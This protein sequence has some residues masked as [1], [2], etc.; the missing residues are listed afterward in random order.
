MIPEQ[1]QPKRRAAR[2]A[3]R[4]ALYPALMVALVVALFFNPRARAEYYYVRWIH[5]TQE[6]KQIKYFEALLAT[7][8][9]QPHAAALAPE[10]IAFYRWKEIDQLLERGDGEVLVPALL[11]ELDTGGTLENLVY[12]AKT[13]YRIDPTSKEIIPIIIG[14]LNSKDAAILLGDIIV[15][16]KTVPP[17]LI[18][19][20]DSGGDRVAL[21]L[22][23][24]SVSSEK[25]KAIVVPALAQV[26]GHES[27]SVRWRAAWALGEIG[28]PARKAVPALVLALVDKDYTVRNRA[29]E[30]LG[31]I[32]PGA[33]MAVP[34]LVKTLADESGW[35]RRVALE[36]LRKIDAR[37]E[38][39]D[40][41]LRKAPKVVYHPCCFSMPR[42]GGSGLDEKQAVSALEKILKDKRP[43]VRQAAAAA[44]KKIQGKP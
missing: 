3:F 1:T 42:R 38:K 33:K 32:G 16:T 23:F 4:M 44:L 36:A 41:P 2:T 43:E 13:L 27:D 5:A 18:A 14:L 25:V 6:K 34:A 8:R 15:E 35:L 9:W 40:R 30:A 21:A 39:V 20:L 7:G 22:V 29:V 12:A 19:A 24:I 28:P 11:D 17:E 37:A 26:L 10:L 31:K